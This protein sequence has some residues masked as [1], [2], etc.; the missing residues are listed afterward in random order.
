MSK[1]EEAKT[2]TVLLY[3]KEIDDKKHNKKWPKD[4]VSYRHKRF[5]VVIVNKFK[6]EIQS[7]LTAG[8]EYPLA[9]ELAEDDYFTKLKKYTRNDGTEG[10]KSVLVISGARSIN[11]G[12]FDSKS[13][14]TIVDDLEE[15]YAKK[16]AEKEESNE[17]NG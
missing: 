8:L 3:Q 4:L 1:K 9:L 10:L 7:A 5:D 6:P 16:L 17:A 14:D 12:K 2:I 15:E 13:L 11:Q